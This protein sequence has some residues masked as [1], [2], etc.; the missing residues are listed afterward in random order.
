MIMISRLKERFKG[1]SM[2]G[3][4]TR[5]IIMLRFSQLPEDGSEVLSPCGIRVQVN[6]LLIPERSTFDNS[7]YFFAYRINVR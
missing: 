4:A 2:N 3:Y 1:I 7:A 5:L 6:A